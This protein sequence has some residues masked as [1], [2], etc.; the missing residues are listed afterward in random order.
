MTL[1]Y[2]FHAHLL[3]KNQPENIF[4]KNK[5]KLNIFISLYQDTTTTGNYYKKIIYTLYTL[6]SKVRRANDSTDYRKR[7][8]QNFKEEIA[9]L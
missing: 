9:I 6:I 2:N 3:T 1:F 5:N 4:Q 8:I 7:K